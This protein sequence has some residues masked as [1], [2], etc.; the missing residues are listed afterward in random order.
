MYFPRPIPRSE[1]HALRR[2]IE[3]GIGSGDNLDGRRLDAARGVHDDTN[4]DATFNSRLPQLLGIPQRRMGKHLWL[5][6]NNGVHKYLAS[7]G[8]QFGPGGTGGS[9]RVVGAVEAVVPHHSLTHLSLAMFRSLLD[10]GH[11]FGAYRVPRPAGARVRRNRKS[12]R[13]RE[14]GLQQRWEQR[15]DA[16]SSFRVYLILVRNEKRR[17]SSPVEPAQGPRVPRVTAAEQPRTN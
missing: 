14:R 11:D 4:Y 13:P 16:F 17:R 10:Q 1:Y 2:L 5:L 8:R 12:T 7:H 15:G 6:L 9:L 3:A